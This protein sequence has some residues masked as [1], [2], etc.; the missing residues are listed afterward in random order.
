MIRKL[1]PWWVSTW[2]LREQDQLY[3]ACWQG[4]WRQQDQLHGECQH[5]SWWHHDQLLESNFSAG[6]H[7]VADDSD[8]RRTNSMVR[9]VW[10]KA[11]L[12]WKQNKHGVQYLVTTGHDLPRRFRSNWGKPD[13]EDSF[14]LSH[15]IY[16][17]PIYTAIFPG[18]GQICCDGFLFI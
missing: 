1:T 9:D 18:L 15:L 4:G 5:C 3:G 14:P 13:G 12:L 7:M 10:F 17:D 16:M 2:R 11:N 8:D 6:V